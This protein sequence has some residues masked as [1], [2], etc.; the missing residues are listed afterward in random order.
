MSYDL[1]E[2]GNL[3]KVLKF[4]GIWPRVSTKSFKCICVNT[5]GLYLAILS[6]TRY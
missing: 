5:Y 4:Q 3:S 1:R 6:L 2:L